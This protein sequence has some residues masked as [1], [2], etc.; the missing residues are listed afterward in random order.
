MK[1]NIRT[2]GLF[3]KP[4]YDDG[5]KIATSEHF[6]QLPA[7]RYNVHNEDES[8]QAFENSVQQIL[9]KI[10]DLEGTQ[11]NLVFK[12][13][14]SITIHFDKYGPTRAGRY[15]EL[16]EWIKLKKACANINNTRPKMFLILYSMHSL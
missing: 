4:E 11:S 12:K 1:L 2:E 9:L 7:T 14:V 3:E 10:R 13:I 8:N 6:Y 15:I 5:N 16:P